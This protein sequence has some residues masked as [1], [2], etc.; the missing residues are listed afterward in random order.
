MITKQI[1]NMVI[2][3]FL[4][5][6]IALDLLTFSYNVGSWDATFFNRV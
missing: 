1:L 4:A 6:S 3:T 5:T 2:F